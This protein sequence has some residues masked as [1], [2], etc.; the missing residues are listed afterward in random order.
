MGNIT[1]FTVIASPRIE[2]SLPSEAPSM[3]TER[4]V[5]LNGRRRVAIHLDSSWI[6]SSPAGSGLL[7]I[8]MGG[9]DRP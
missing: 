2:G 5:R 1:N 9:G 4:T 3:I 6:A 7:A 8:T